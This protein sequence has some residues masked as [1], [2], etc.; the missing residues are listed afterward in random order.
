[1]PSTEGQYQ[2]LLDRL[3]T[4][5]VD[6][7]LTDIDSM[8]IEG[9]LRIM[10]EQD[11]LVAN[12]V[13]T[14]IP[15]IARAVA[16]AAHSFRAGG[17]LLYVGAGTSGRLGILDA[18]ECPP[19]FGVSRH[20][21]Q[22]IIA[23][24]ERAVFEAVEDAEDDVTAGAAAII[25][26]DVNPN[27][28]VIGI[29]ASGRTPFVLGALHQ[30]RKRGAATVG[31]TNN[32]PSEIDSV[33]SI[34]IAPVVGPEVLAGSTRLKS[35]TAQK[36]V[37]NMISTI[38]MMEVGKTYGNLMVD[39]Q[40]TNAKLRVRSARMITEVTGADRDSA[41]AALESAGGSAK[42]AILMIETGLDADKGTQLLERAGGSLRRALGT[43]E[44][45]SP[46]SDM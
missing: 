44:H 34:I 28:T 32:R 9:R 11:S 26:A 5:S 3:V 7:G 45:R 40:A 8:D 1:M 19:T 17:R 23:G 2:P 15:R 10:N 42:L 21:V 38:A 39:L 14:E 29:S 16:H 12:A 13:A 22:G 25:N 6:P 4:E 31:L 37:L 18:S 36:M 20:W 46:N 24:G 33:A 43:P 27:D 35:G 41:A 30:A